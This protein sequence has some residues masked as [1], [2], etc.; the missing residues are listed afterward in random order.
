M[1]YVVITSLSTVVLQ[2]FPLPPAAGHSEVD[3]FLTEH[4]KWRI[5]SLELRVEKLKRDHMIL[6]IKFISKQAIDGEAKVKDGPFKGK[7]QS[8][9]SYFET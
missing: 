4:E 6:M 1:S 5:N 8:P 7:G 9:Q 3:W 2:L